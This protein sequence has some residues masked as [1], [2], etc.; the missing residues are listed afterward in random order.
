M[1]KGL[2]IERGDSA[3]L[4]SSLI[5]QAKS[6]SNILTFVINLS[7]KQVRMIIWPEK[8]AYI[9]LSG[10]LLCSCGIR[11]GSGT[12]ALAVPIGTRVDQGDIVLAES[13]D[14]HPPEHPVSISQRTCSLD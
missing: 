3:E 5:A 8:I 14:F 13:S 10:N 2:S 4:V 11:L 7:L 1:Y 12:L 6:Q 9:H